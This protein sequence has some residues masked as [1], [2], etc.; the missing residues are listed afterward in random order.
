MVKLNADKTSSRRKMRKAHFGASSVE[1][2]VR[3]AAPL[4]KDLFLRYK[5][6]SMPVIKGDEVKVLRGDCKGKEGKVLGV[7]RN[8]YVIHVERCTRDKSNGQQIPI[9]IDASN[10]VITNLKIDKSRKAIL[11]RKRSGNKTKESA[12]GMGALVD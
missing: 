10:V 11:A 2:R 5:V 1:R 4:K 3:M 6:R 8:K 9:G 12:G 7:Q